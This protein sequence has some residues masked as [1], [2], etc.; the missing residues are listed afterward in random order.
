MKT[1]FSILI[2]F[3]IPFSTIAQETQAIDSTRGITTIDYKTTGNTVQFTPQTPAL[4]Q[5]AGAPKA[6]YSHYWE[7]GDG[8]YSKAENTQT[9]L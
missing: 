7:F 2:F 8:N 3:A 9:Y 5:I 6:F 1:L 4:N